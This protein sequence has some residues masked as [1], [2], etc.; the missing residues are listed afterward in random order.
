[1][2]ETNVHILKC[3][4]DPFQ[5]V[6]DGRKLA[7]FRRD[8]RGFEVGD[9]LT[10][11]EWVP[12]IAAS[13]PMGEDRYTGRILAR[14]ITDIRRGGRFGIPDGYAML[15]LG[16]IDDPRDMPPGPSALYDLVEWDEIDDPRERS[17]HVVAWDDHLIVDPDVSATSPVVRGTWV[18]VGHVVSEIVDGST[19][20]DILRTHPELTEDDIRACLAYA[21]NDQIEGHDAR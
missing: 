3:W 7:E 9:I 15:S 10:L 14:K 17:G 2:S 20:P 21:V 4:P 18:T 16:T 13:A 11:R 6:W 1:M 5:A 12:D 19:W 8:D